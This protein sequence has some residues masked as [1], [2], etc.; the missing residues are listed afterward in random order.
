MKGE[1]L[2]GGSSVI[3]ELLHIERGPVE[4]VR[5]ISVRKLLGPTGGFPGTGG[6]TYPIWPWET[7]WD[8]TGGAGKG[9]QR[10]V[11]NTR[12]S[13]RPQS[14]VHEV[15]TWGEWVGGLFHFPVPGKDEKIESRSRGKHLKLCSFS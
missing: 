12:L 14:R 4:V 13:P 10:D 2:G 9:E 5:G 6:M 8:P 15:R 7:P 3:A 11:W 1:E